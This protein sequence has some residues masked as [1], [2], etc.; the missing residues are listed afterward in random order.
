MREEF[1]IAN[2]V[3]TAEGA[4][5]I[6]MEEMPITIYNSRAVVVG[7]GRIGKILSNSLKLLGCDVTVVARKESARA[8][9]RAN[10]LKAVGFSKMCEEIE[11]AD[12]L[13][14]TV[15]QM[16]IDK[17]A[18]MHAKDT[19]ILDLASKPGGVEF[20]AARDI[21]VKVI[22]AIGLPGK[23]AP[24]SAGKIIKDTITN[25]FSEIEL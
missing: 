1:E 9:A 12:V 2:A 4:I 24:I 3:P 5:Q 11:K 19:L 21:G 17:N 20:D 7:Y 15:P 16:V 18:L 25:I 6:A 22:W 10:C 13:F 23:V 8:L 14:N